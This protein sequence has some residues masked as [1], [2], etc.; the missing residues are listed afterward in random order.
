[1]E[2]CDVMQEMSICSKRAFKKRCLAPLS[3]FF[4]SCFPPFALHHSERSDLSSTIFV[5]LFALS[6]G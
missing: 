6:F 3:L 4:L 2:A 5:Y 1:M